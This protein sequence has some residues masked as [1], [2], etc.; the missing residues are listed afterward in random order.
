MVI[1][2][3]TLTYKRGTSTTVLFVIVTKPGSSGKAVPTQALCTN[4]IDLYKGL[5]PGVD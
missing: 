3:D 2:T 4:V 1:G 5:I